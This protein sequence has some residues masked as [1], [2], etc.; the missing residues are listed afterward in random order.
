M[1]TIR[2]IEKGELRQSD[3]PGLLPELLSRKEVL[4]WADVQGASEEDLQALNAHFAFHPLAIEDALHT[5]QRPKLDEYEDHLFL[6][7]YEAEMGKQKLKTQQ[8]GIFLRSNLVLTVHSGPSAAV[9]ALASRCAAR[10][11]VASAGA[12]FLVYSLLDVLT[13][14]YFPM[15]EVID[16]QIDR[17]E[18]RVLKGAQGVLDDIFY[19]KRNIAHYRKLLGPMRDVV[20]LLITHEDSMVQRRTIPYLRDVADHLIRLY[21]IAETQRDLIGGVQDAYLSTI[22]NQ[23]NQVMQRLTIVA[24]I[25][26]PLTF[27][28]GLFGMNLHASPWFFEWDR[29]QIFW[30]ILIVLGAIA[31]AMAWWFHR[32]RLL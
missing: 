32:K 24:V 28:T 26:L 30:G 31:A 8:L 10:H 16:A 1:L 2:W 6:V 3:D 25:F 9:E 18:N 21:E 29:G 5:H 11:T 4:V 19:L 23:L 15:A 7:A 14:R 13:D 22:N 12:D 27:V 20:T 17:L